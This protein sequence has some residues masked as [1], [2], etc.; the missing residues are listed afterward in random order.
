MDV[1]L[2]LSKVNNKDNKITSTG[3]AQVSLLQKQSFGSVL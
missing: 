1:A 2:Y 3:I